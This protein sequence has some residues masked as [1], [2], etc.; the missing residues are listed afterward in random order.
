MMPEGCN[1]FMRNALQKSV[2]EE[3][4]YIWGGGVSL[5]IRLNGLVLFVE[6]GEIRNQI[7]DDVGVGKRVDLDVFICFLGDSTCRGVSGRFCKIIGVKYSLS[8]GRMALTIAKQLLKQSS[9]KRDAS[10]A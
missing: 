4:S 7:L 1:K 3:E 10:R 9:C 5:Q 2:G 6:V 8:E